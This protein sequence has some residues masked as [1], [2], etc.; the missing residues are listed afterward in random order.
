MVAEGEYKN[1]KGILKPEQQSMWECSSGEGESDD[2]RDRNEDLGSGAW[3]DQSLHGEVNFWQDTSSII[4][5]RN[6]LNKYTGG[7]G[8][9]GE[10]MQ[11]LSASIF[12]M[13]GDFSL[14]YVSWR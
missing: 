8:S 2:R 11:I 9:D 12:T 1:K 4:N 13:E 6:T 14:C 7:W 10:K 3:E 5:D